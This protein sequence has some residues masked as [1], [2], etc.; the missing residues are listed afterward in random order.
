[1]TPRT[2]ETGSILI[3]ALV[4]VL[5]VAA[6]TGLW[7]ET[8]ARVAGQ[9]ERAA[10]R[11]TA[12]LVAQSQLATVGVLNVVVPG[13]TRGRNADFDWRIAIEPNPDAGPGVD[14]VEVSVSRDGKGRLA[15]LRTL[16][17]GQ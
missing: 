9:H 3:E 17:L 7:F 5:I 15:T 4:A 11:R 16:R 10:D 2:G 1:V 12:M 14:T 8:V 13:E 6:V